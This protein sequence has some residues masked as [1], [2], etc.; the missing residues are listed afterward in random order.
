M[1]DTWT[2]A[3]LSL[4]NS[5]LGDA[6]VRVALGDERQHLALTPRQPE[7][8]ERDGRR[9]GQVRIDDAIDRCH[10]AD[11]S[12]FRDPYPRP[13]SEPFD[14]AAEWAGAEAIRYGMC[15]HER[16]LGVATWR[17]RPEQ[18]LCKPEPRVGDRPDD[19]GPIRGVD[20][21]TPRIRCRVAVRSMAFGERE[22]HHALEATPEGVR[23]GQLGPYLLEDRRGIA[24]AGAGPR[25]PC[26]VAE[27]TSQARSIGFGASGY[28]G[29]LGDVVVVARSAPVDRGHRPRRSPR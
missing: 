29:E 7:T 27:R 24:G 26:V 19:A 3:V 23:S 8:V 20:R 22:S 15:R 16:C 21:R 11:R 25:G 5:A 4:M 9:G 1:F 2:P 6:P 18:R 14:P 28:G 13:A 10:G 17:A 12:R